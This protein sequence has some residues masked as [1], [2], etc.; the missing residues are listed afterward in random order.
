QLRSSSRSTRSTKRCPWTAGRSSAWRSSARASGLAG[1]LRLRRALPRSIA[2]DFGCVAAVVHV[3][4]ATCVVAALVDEEPL[5]CRGATLADAHEVPLR[6][7]Q[8]PVCAG[9][10]PQR[11]VQR[12]LFRPLVRNVRP[13]LHE[14]RVFQRGELFLLDRG[15]VGRIGAP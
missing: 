11:S 4:P 10:V 3:A 9:D 14:V 12:E 6:T 2:T 13:A 7:K 1:R 8:L 15:A 5:A